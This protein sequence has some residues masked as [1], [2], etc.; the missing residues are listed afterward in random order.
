MWSLDQSLVFL[1]FLWE[2]LSW[3]QVDKDLTRKTAYFEGWSCFKFN[4][5]WLTLRTNLK[6]YTSIGKG[7][8]L[9]VR[10]FWGLICTFLEVTRE[11]LVGGRFFPLTPTSPLIL[12]RVT[13]AYKINQTFWRDTFTK[14][15]FSK[16]K[17]F[18]CQ[19]FDYEGY[20][21]QIV[22]S[23]II[24]ISR[25]EDSNKKM[26]TLNNHFFFFFFFSKLRNNL[27]KFATKRACS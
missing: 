25:T 24:N 13:S 20:P 11:K 12:N 23:E 19:K 17:M 9:K 10:K 1:A 15:Y 2:K 21:S 22:S 3:P 27:Q 14:R 6:F 8:K 18:I 4:N 7:L 16:E 5:L 26:N